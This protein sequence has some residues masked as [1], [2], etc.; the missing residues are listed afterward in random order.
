MYRPSAYAVDDVSTLYDVIRARSFATIATVLNGE[1]AF[2]YAPVVLGDVTDGK[3]V[4]EYHLARGNPLASLDRAKVRISFLGPDGY[5]SPDWYGAEGFVPT[6][7]YIVVEASGIAEQLSGGELRNLLERLSA[8]HEAR[9]LPKKP[10]VLDKLPASRIDQLLHAIV[11]FRV[12][13]ETL[14]GKFKLSQDKKPEA[15]AGVIS[16]LEATDTST[17]RA[18][19]AAMRVNADKSR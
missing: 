11:G 18:V 8:E 19:A 10:W 17:N 16:A 1:P 13:L 6:W 12:R 14:E 7:N 3:G 5:V 4:L 2:A 9:L 15:R